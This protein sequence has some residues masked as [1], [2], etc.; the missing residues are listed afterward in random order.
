MRVV[1]IG[2]LHPP[3]RQ[4]A[5]AKLSRRVAYDQHGLRDLRF[6]GA[7]GLRD[8]AGL[9]LVDHESLTAGGIDQRRSALA[10]KPVNRLAEQRGQR[11]L[12]HTSQTTGSYGLGRRSGDAGG[13]QRGLG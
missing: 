3:C 1:G 10:N 13:R 5:P 2:Q 12:V 9:R 11:D 7:I 6:F 8:L 4:V